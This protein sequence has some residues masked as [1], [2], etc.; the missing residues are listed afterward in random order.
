MGSVSFDFEWQ[1]APGVRDELLAATWARLSLKAGDSYV[2]EAIDLGSQSH[3]T[4]IYGSLFPVA[5]WIV[6]HWWH[7]L[8][9]PAPQTPLP[10]GR[11]GVE[12]IRGWV[13]RHNLLAA[14]EGGALPD[15]T[16]ARDG[17]DVLLRWVADPASRAPRRL[18]FVGQDDAHVSCSELENTMGRLVEAV[19]SRLRELLGENE[20]VVRLAEGWHAIRAADASEAELCRFLAILGV[21]PYD[22]D[23]ATDALAQTVERGIEALEGDLR[24]DFFEGSEPGSLIEDLSWVEG[25]LGVLRGVNGSNGIPTIAP[26][27]APSAHEVGYLASR[28]VRAELL[29]LAADEPIQDLESV[30]VDRLGWARDCSRIRKG[31]VQLDGMVGLDSESSS[32]VLLTAGKR[33]PVAERFRLA[34]AAYF[35][36]MA[37]LGSSARLLSKSVTFEQRAARAFAAELLAPAAF[38]AKRVAGRMSFEDVEE[39][40]ADLTVSPQVVRHQVENHGLGYLA[41]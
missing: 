10:S 30:L 41:A 33:S 34:R 4:G 19:L 39:I 9:E 1:D 35:P 6:E 23:E 20:D 17:K 18:R 38:L 16:I 8:Y 26:E 22:P 28:R 32:P 29:R 37:S 24:A 31:D 27:T 21:D 12:A 25:A 5:E 15:L 40:A 13:Q 3:R 11:S 14:R 7:L 2:S 36:V